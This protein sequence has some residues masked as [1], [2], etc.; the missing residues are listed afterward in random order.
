[1]MMMM[2]ITNLDDEDIHYTIST[3]LHLFLLAHS[4]AL[5][6]P[7]LL[8][9]CSLVENQAKPTHYAEAFDIDSTT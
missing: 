3:T 7:N 4:S 8:G 2:M 9:F 6:S 5:I 1:M